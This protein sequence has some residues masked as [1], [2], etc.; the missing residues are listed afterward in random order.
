MTISKDH[1]PNAEEILMALD[2]VEQTLEVMTNVVDRLKGK[3]QSEFNQEDQAKKIAQL[4]LE[5]TSSPD[6]KLH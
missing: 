1:E 5:Q 6:D 4:S 2:Q 3:L